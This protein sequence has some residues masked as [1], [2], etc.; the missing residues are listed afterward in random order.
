MGDDLAEAFGIGGLDEVGVAAGDVAGVDVFLLVGGSE[1]DDGEC[2]GTGVLADVAEYLET[3]AAG[4][5]VVE[6]DE[7]EA[8]GRGLGLGGGVEIIEG[9]L[10]A[11]DDVEL[12]SGCDLP[13]GALDEEYVVGAVFDIEGQSD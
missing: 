2:A 10:A 5:V 7:L 12:D 3:G 9:G 6:E 11:V 13:E 8:F 4:E 1:H